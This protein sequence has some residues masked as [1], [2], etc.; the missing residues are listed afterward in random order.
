M[1]CDPRDV[2]DELSD[3]IS[4]PRLIVEVLSDSTEKHDRGTKFDLYRGRDTL[5][6]YMLI[7]TKRVGVEVR[8]RDADGVWPATTYGSGQAVYLASVDMDIPIQALYRGTAL[9][10]RTTDGQ[11]VRIT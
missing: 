2:A 10:S 1:T 6:E 4:N 9:Q 7:E 11:N 5:M 8:T 3:Y